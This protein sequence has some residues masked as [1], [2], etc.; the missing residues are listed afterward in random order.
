MK[1]RPRA[2]DLGLCLRSIEAPARLIDTGGQAKGD[3]IT[4]RIPIAAIGDIDKEV[5]TWFR[6]AYDLAGSETANKPKPAM[7][8]QAKKT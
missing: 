6:R 1:P 4:H 3:R 5:E 7:R 8:K 2:R